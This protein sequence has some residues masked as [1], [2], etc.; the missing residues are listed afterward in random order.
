MGSAGSPGRIGKAARSASLPTASVPMRSERS[1]A[2]A[3]PIVASSSDFAGGAAARR[4]SSRMSIASLLAMESEPSPVRMPSASIVAR[5]AVPCPR[6]AFDAG[7][8]ATAQSW[9]AIMRRS[10]FDARMQWMSSGRAASTSS[11]SSNE[12]GEMARDT[13]VIPRA[14]SATAKGPRAIADERGLL[15]ALGD[16][17]RERAAHVRDEREERVAHRVGRMRRDAEPH[18]IRRARIERG[19]FSFESAHRL[20]DVGGIGRRAE[21]F[22]VHDAAHAGL[23]HRFERDAGIA[24]VGE[25]GDAGAQTIGDAGARGVEVALARHDRRFRGLERHDPFA[26]GRRADE[27]VEGGELEMRV[28]VDEAGQHVRVAEVAIVAG[29]RI[30]AR[31]GVDDATVLFDDGAALHW[32]ARDGDDPARVVADHGLIAPAEGS[33]GS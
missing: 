33:R 26:E 29:R 3:P 27:S 11:C 22:L 12:I 28:R 5:G 31:T 32:R 20:G 10:V 30:G 4:A 21:H 23:A 24:R 13:T 18:E 17:D 8:C 14:R 9:A 7:Q 19:E 6:C 16:M 15:L 2:R 25:G 1:R